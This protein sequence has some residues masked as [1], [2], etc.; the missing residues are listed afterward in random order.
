MALK[1]QRQI[2]K[3]AQIPNYFAKTPRNLLLKLTLLKE[4]CRHDLHSG[5]TPAHKQPSY[6][7]KRPS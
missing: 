4:V 1:L 3:L 6:Y 2:S 5:K 7:V